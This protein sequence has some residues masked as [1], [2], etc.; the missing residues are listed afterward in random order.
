GSAG[1]CLAPRYACVRTRVKGRSVSLV[2]TTPDGLDI[3]SL[4]RAHAA[5]LQIVRETPVLT[6]RS[7]SE[8]LGGRLGVK[9]E[10][11][12]RTGSFKLRG[13]FTKLASLPDDVAARGVVAASAGNHGQSLAYAARARGVPC[14]V[15][16]PESASVSK[17]AAVRAFGG[18]VVL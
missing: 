13:A 18:E 6:A 2:V 12:Q 17:C 4:R 5:A 11:L 14:V 7:L 10:K 15:H 9:A 16:M 8:R 3:E 1:D